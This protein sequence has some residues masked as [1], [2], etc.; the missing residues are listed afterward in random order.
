[1]VR[2]SSVYVCQTCSYE[3]GK[4]FG[5]C[6]E[7]DSW[8]SM[9]EMAV[10]ASK[11]K[12]SKSRTA[13]VA[14]QGVSLNSIKPKDT[15][16]V[17]TK[18]TE[19]DRVL[20]GGIVPGQVILIAG[21]PGVGKSTI[22]LQLSEKMGET[23]YVSGEESVYQ[24]KIRADRMG[25]KN[26]SIDVLEETDIDEV[27]AQVESP[28]Y[29]NDSLLIIDS[30]QTMKTADLSGMSGSVGQ[31][32]ECTYRLVKLA[33]SKNIP[34]IVVGH[35]TKQGS[36]AG[37]SVLMHLVDTVLWFEGSKD[38]QYRLLRSR[39]NRFGPTDE[40]G[41]FTM[42][43]KGLIS[44]EDA[45]GLFLSEDT[46]GIPGSCKTMIMEGTRP[47]MVEIQSLT[48]PTKLAFARRV[49]NGI[50]SK[51]LEVIIAVLQRRC[52]LNLADFD[53]YV[54]VV[55]GIKIKDPAIDLA[56]CMSIASSYREKPVDG[57]VVAIGEV[58]LLGEVRQASVEKKR[59]QEAKRLG[60]KI[61]KRT[62]GKRFVGKF[63]A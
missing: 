28:G 5:K 25:I 22:L 47:V 41:I 18:I 31:I 20:G 21:E 48:V 3:S 15:K 38:L 29:K 52:R 34:I 8:G 49:A 59:I 23:T 62:P 54:N 24:I 27:I 2:S 33:K 63:I 60:M 26:S 17:A 10:S 44:I 36:V 55:G 11:N 56:I 9:V 1:M 40:V 30:I 39:K 19:L 57:E 43:E 35:V 45:S 50:D 4:W 13:Q 42:E 6:P 16:R 53:V 51:K 61:V 37:P 46:K 7:C 58:G 32:R 14:K 12:S